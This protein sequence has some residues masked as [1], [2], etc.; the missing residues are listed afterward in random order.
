[1]NF[2]KILM[3]LFLMVITFSAQARSPNNCPP[4]VKASFMTQNNDGHSSYVNPDL[5]KFLKWLHHATKFDLNKPMLDIGA[6]HGGGTYELIK[7]GAKQIYV[8]DLDKN[9]LDCMRSYISKYTRKN[10]ADIIYL[11]GDISS[12]GILKKLPNHELS[13]VFAK[14]AIQFLSYHQLMTLIK[15]FN[16]KVAKGGIVVIIFENPYWKKLDLMIAGIFKERRKYPNMALENIVKIAYQDVVFPGLR[17]CSFDAYQK[18]PEDMRLPG[19]PCKLPLENGY[20]QLLNPYI[21]V[22]LMRSAGFNY[23]LDEAYPNH[24]KTEL[25]V[26][27]KAHALNDSQINA[28][29]KKWVKTQLTRSIL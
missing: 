29:F 3:I 9:N 21:I 6:G 18:A 17:R 5:D 23:I 8:N 27:S 13:F 7:L 22:A 24:E 19:F 2:I 25:L 10:N 26:F 14:N 16:Q 11:P 15:A 4:F 12:D 1:M 20:G 28:S